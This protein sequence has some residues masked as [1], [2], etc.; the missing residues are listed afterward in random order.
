VDARVNNSSPGSG[1]RYV[2][3]ALALATTCVLCLLGTAR[4]SALSLGVG[5]SEGGRNV[6][7]M[8]LVAKSGATMFRVPMSQPWFDDELVQ[9]AS[10]NGVSILANLAPD[11]LPQGKQ[12]TEYL[13]WVTEVVERYGY[14]GAYWDEHPNVPYQPIP[15]WEITNEPND[16]QF[17]PLEFGL[18]VS[19]VAATIQAA[20]SSQADR[21]TEVITGGLLAFGD[22]G[23]TEGNWFE[24]GKDSFQGAIAYLEAAYPYFSTSPN[25]TGVAFHP[26]ELDPATFGTV[27]GNPEGVGYLEA[28]AY[29]VSGAHAALAALAG[30]EEAALPLWITET[31]IP[32]AGAQYAAGGAEGQAFVLG[33][34]IGYAQENE[35]ALKLRNLDWYNIR[36]TLGLS[37]EWGR[38]CGLRSIDG[39]L[40]PAFAEF[41]ARAGVPQSMPEQPVAETGI[42][43]EV[44]G[45]RATIAGTVVPG[46]LPTTYAFEYGTTIAY[47]ATTPAADAGAGEVPVVGATPLVGLES[48][49]T[50]HYRLVATNA[51]G[52]TAGADAELTVSPA[53]S[54]PG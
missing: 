50:Y 39:E 24:R 41:Q 48:G 34:L 17:S 33:Q 10:E 2:R 27:P 53:Q 29:S 14:G 44:E 47:G 16:H 8:P 26:Y 3:F 49:A 35:A 42:A 45:D 7:E 23:Q 32:G 54:H 40:R 1:Y 43:A 52:T 21:A 19:E 18:F 22:H 4:A 5:W 13:Q 37:E 30:S 12:R 31:G 25:V 15:A 46:G 51:L 9:A 11:P 20:S 38:Y 6:E 28:F 36:D